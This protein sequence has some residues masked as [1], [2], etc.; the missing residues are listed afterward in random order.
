M[1]AWV[2]RDSDGTLRAFDNEPERHSTYETTGPFDHPYDGSEV[3]VCG[4]WGRHKLEG[5]K[6]H[7]N[8]FKEVTWKSKPKRVNIKITRT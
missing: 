8:T 7:P 2:A 1:Y 5:I 3:F 4:H 6:L